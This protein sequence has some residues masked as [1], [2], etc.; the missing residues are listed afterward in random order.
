[1]IILLLIVT[2]WVFSLPAGGK[3][4]IIISEF[5]FSEYKRLILKT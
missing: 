5:Q 3:N 4:Q 1:M 2:M